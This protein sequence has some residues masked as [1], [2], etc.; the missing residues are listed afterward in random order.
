ME[1]TTNVI[2]EKDILVPGNFYGIEGIY[3][4][5]FSVPFKIKQFPVMYVRQEKLRDGDYHVLAGAE[6]GIL[7]RI[8]FGLD[9]LVFGDQRNVWIKP[10]GELVVNSIINPRE[11]RTEKVNSFIEEAYRLIREGP[12]ASTFEEDAYQSAGIQG[13]GEKEARLKLIIDYYMRKAD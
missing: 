4:K 13:F 7:S 5:F 12:N 2:A 3:T 1:E 8:R 9:D 6:E 10:K 11:Q